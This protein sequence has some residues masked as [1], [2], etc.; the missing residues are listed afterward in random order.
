MKVHLF[1][2]PLLLWYISSAKWPELR[3]FVWHFLELKLWTSCCAS[4]SSRAYLLR[5]PSATDQQPSGLHWF[6][7]PDFFSTG[8]FLY[9]PPLI[10]YP[11]ASSITVAVVYVSSLVSGM[12]RKAA[13]TSASDSSAGALSVSRGSHALSWVAT[14][15]LATIVNLCSVDV[16]HRRGLS[17]VQFSSSAF[18]L[19]GVAHYVHTAH[20]CSLCAVAS[21]SPASMVAVFYWCCCTELPGASWSVWRLAFYSLKVP[22]C[23]A[24]NL[25]NW[26]G[27]NSSM[28][29]IPHCWGTLI[30]CMHWLGFE[31]LTYVGTNIATIPL[32][33]TQLD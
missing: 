27:W 16:W 6:W 13:C 17:V 19:P 8:G 11:N 5:H 18:L 25:S 7:F 22:A 29:S 15:S 9:F 28:A 14:L 21:R 2:W 33:R 1:S 30:G 32:V 4:S 24:Y 26:I 3:A 20:R 10:L 31:P 12:G 23:V